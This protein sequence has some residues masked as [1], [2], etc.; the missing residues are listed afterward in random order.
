MDGSDA[1]EGNTAE[2]KQTRSLHPPLCLGLAVAL[3][4]IDWETSRT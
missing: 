4:L 2:E 3:A 1:S